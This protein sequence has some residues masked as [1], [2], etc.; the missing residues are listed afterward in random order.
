[1]FLFRPR[2]FIVAL[3]IFIIEVLIALYVHDAIIRP[4][5]GDLLVVIMIYCFLRAFFSWSVKTAALITL[6]FAYLIEALQYINIVERLQLQH[7]RLARVVIGTYFSR[8]D[9]LAYTIGVVLVLLAE[10]LFGR[11]SV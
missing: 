6:L 2:Y 1:M 10:R 4:H 3:V 11:V 5:I 8:I 9:I 7:S